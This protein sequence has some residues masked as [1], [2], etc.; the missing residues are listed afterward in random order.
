MASCVSPARPPCPR[1]SSAQSKQMINHRGGEF[2]A[3]IADIT[4]KV[5]GIY[6]TKNDLLF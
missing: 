1:G 6:Q 4:N 2:H 3:M 5:K